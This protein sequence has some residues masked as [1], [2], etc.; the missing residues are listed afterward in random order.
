MWKNYFVNQGQHGMIP[1]LLFAL[2]QITFLQH[3]SKKEKKRKEKKQKTKQKTKQLSYSPLLIASLMDDVTFTFWIKGII[4]ERNTPWTWQRG[5]VSYSIKVPTI[6]ISLVVFNTKTHNLVGILDY[7]KVRN[8]FTYCFKKIFK[9]H[10]P[11]RVMSTSGPL[12]RN[13]S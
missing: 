1:S 3:T 2:Q 11:F 8:F 9:I 13:K 7:S 12:P 4:M 6:A 10:L 5:Q